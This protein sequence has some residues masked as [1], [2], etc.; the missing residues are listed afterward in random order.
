MSRDYGTVTGSEYA[1]GGIGLGP[2]VSL[3]EH[4][5]YPVPEVTSR[6]GIAG[7]E[8]KAVTDLANLARK[9]NYEVRIQYAR[10]RF[11]H[12]S[13]GTPGAVK[14]SIGLVMERGVVRAVA[15]YAGSAKTAVYAGSAKTWTWGTLAVQVPGAWPERFATMDAFLEGVFGPVC[16]PVKAASPMEGP[17]R[18]ALKK[19]GPLLP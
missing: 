14:D 7:P 1:G 11:V 12:A 16:Q 19:W 3:M 17:A 2:R 10:G 13:L 9:W 8:R 6:M 4:E 18:R 5:P 15:V